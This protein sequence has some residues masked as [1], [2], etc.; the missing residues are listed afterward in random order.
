MPRIENKKNMSTETKREAVYGGRKYGVSSAQGV[1]GVIIK[2]S[3]S[4]Y[5]FRVYSESGEFTD[6]DLIHEDLAVT[7]SAGEL[8]SFYSSEEANFLDH[9]PEVLGLNTK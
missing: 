5:C 7:I 9:S 8:A 3:N 6:Y 2:T 4:K 1:S